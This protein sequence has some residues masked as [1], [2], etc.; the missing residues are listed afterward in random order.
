[1]PK[2]VPWHYFIHQH[3]QTFPFW[4]IQAE[5]IQRTEVLDDK[6]SKVF[7]RPTPLKSLFKKELLISYCCPTSS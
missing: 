3:P 5:H 2:N 1:M 6:F 4:D 7:C